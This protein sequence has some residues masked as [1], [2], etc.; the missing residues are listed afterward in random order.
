MHRQPEPWRIAGPID[1]VMRGVRR[2]ASRRMR[3]R[4]KQNRV[5]VSRDP[6]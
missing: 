6:I 3:A 4:S 1:P 2:S 5:A